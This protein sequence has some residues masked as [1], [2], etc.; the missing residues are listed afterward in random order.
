MLGSQTQLPKI[1][2]AL[3]VGHRGWIGSQI[4]A[5]LQ[6]Q[7]VQVE[8]ATARPENAGAFEAELDSKSPSHVFLCFGRTHGRDRDGNRFLTIDV[9]E[10]PGM[11]PTNLRDNLVAV[12]AAAAICSRRQVHVTYIGTG[13]IYSASPGCAAFGEEDPPNFQASSYSAAKSATDQLLQILFPNTVLNLRIRMPI[14]GYHHERNFVTKLTKY[15]KIC[16]IPN[17]M[18]VL[19]DLLPAALTFASERRTGTLNFTNPGTISHNEVLEMYRDT[20]DHSFTWENF[21]L[22]EQSR[23]LAAPRSNNELD[24]AKLRSWWPGVPDVRASLRRLF[25]SWGRQPGS[26]I[27]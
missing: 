19:P 7:K 12:L 17:S 26:H 22:E 27:P 11:L 15:P 21:S 3:V 24:S 13:C 5:L 18:T 8:G 4:F 14:V 20:V 16:S 10:Q 1:D 25:H 2:K 9:L 6:E 23:V